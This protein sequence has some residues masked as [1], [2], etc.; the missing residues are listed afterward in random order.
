MAGPPGSFSGDLTAL[1]ATV[2]CQV[3]SLLRI[4]PKVILYKENKCGMHGDV[5]CGMVYDAAKL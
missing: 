2:L 4:R 5:H 1:L 3:T